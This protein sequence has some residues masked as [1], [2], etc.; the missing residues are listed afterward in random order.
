MNSTS[1]KKL[2][3]VDDNET[4]SKMY[5]THFTLRGFEVNVVGDGEAA[6]ATAI[7]YKP[8]LILLD[9]MMPKI[10][11]FDVLDILHNTE[12]TKRIPIIMVTALGEKKDRDRAQSSGAVEYFVKSETDLETITKKINERLGIQ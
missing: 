7:D 10:N 9:V 2:L 5:A 12:Q 3:I 1:P 11:G 6:L 4:I 8:D